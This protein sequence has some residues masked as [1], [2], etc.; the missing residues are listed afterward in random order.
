MADRKKYVVVGLGNR[1]RMYINALVDKYSDRCELVAVCDRNPGRIELWKES[2]AENGADVKG[3]PAER[4]EEMIRETRPDTVVV[5]TQDSEHDKYICRAMELGCDVITEKPMTTDAEKCRRILETQRRTGRQC[6]VA[7][8]YRYSPPRTQIKHLLMSGIIGE[9]HSVNF[10]W[11]LNTRHGADYFR[12]WHRRKENSGGLLVHKATHHFD[13]VNWWM[14]TVPENVFARGARNFYTPATA[15]RYGLARRGERCRGCPESARCPFYLDL[16]AT[17]RMK[18]VYLDNERHDGYFRDR[19]VFGPEIDI[20][21]TMY[22]SVGY[23]NGVLMNYSLHAY[24]PWEGYSVSFNGSLGRLEHKCQ[25]K[26]YVSGDG[27]VPNEL[28]P[29]GTSIGVFPHFQSPY[30]L[31]VWKGEGG[32]G[33][34][35]PVL[36]TDLFSPDPPVD[37]YRR[38]ADQRAGA[39]SILTGIAGNLSI[40]SGSPVRIGD[41]VDA[42]EDPDFSAMPKADEPIDP[43][44]YL[45]AQSSRG[46]FYGHPTKD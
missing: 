25:E 41:L 40:D 17:P 16:S 45:E 3:Y 6:R 30:T 1:C 46:A 2:A 33:G 19:C 10:Q 38:A 7:F 18:T 37:R 24:M 29:E 12:R 31:E 22:L 11:L 35:D 5:T 8:N 36:L 4:F 21:D 14:S 32:H 13:L 9:I 26:T 44:P 15:D 34:G 23:R 28:L 42:L 39:W 27:S 20:E 43:T